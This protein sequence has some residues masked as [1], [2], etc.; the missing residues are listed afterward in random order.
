MHVKIV[1]LS[2]LND[3]KSHN[4]IITAKSISSTHRSMIENNER[5]MFFNL[6]YLQ[7][8]MDFIVHL[9]K[10]YIFFEMIHSTKC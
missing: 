6:I 8:K 3:V 2:D 7:E 5:S 10:L 9:Y 1:I 4:L